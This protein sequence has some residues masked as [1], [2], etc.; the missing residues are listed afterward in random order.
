[1]RGGKRCLLLVLCVVRVYV[2]N[3]LKDFCV[4]LAAADSSSS[5]VSLGN[6][7][8]LGNGEMDLVKHTWKLKRV[9]LQDDDDLQQSNR[10]CGW[11]YP[12]VQVMNFL[13]LKTC[14]L[15]SAFLLVQ[16]MRSLW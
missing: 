12:S 3:T 16:W 8:H 7:L 10:K 14:L 9:L 1:M 13:Q 15:T 11:T 2:G 4:V 5:G 6:D